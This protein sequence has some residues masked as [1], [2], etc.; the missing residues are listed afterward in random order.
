MEKREI[1][2]EVYNK[3][4]KEIPEIIIQMLPEE[5]V[6]LLKYAKR[7]KEIK[8]SNGID[9]NIKEKMK[10]YL[11]SDE[12]Y[13]KTFFYTMAI[14]FYNKKPVENPKIYV[15]AAQ[16]GSGKSN[17]TAKILN[18][19]ENCVFVDSD[20][21]K[22]FRFDAQ[23][24][25]KKHQILYA[26]L[27]GPDSYDHAENI[28]EYALKNKYN[29]IKEAAPSL[30]K[31]LIEE[32]IDKENLSV[33]ILA[34][35]EL[36]SLLSIHERYE[37]Q[38]IHGLKTAKLT[39]INRH[40]ESYKALEKNVGELEKDLEVIIYKRGNIENNFTPIE[41]YPSG[42]YKSMLEALQKERKKDN[43]KTKKEMEKRYKTI[44]NQ[45]KI[46]NA[47]KEEKAQIQRIYNK[48]KN[49]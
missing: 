36:N 29:I 42:E 49:N 48:S 7:V 27:T 38:I 44:I 28:Y 19:N 10:Q 17:L 18:E 16:T 21:Y 30:T 33:H 9:E 37:L 13:L 23:E 46:R 20:K 25:A 15:V 22:H 4:K 12:E 3:I 8:F 1:K 14:T 26:Y 5:P 35:G 45:M 40:N 24:I 2:I 43:I 41:V 11:L 39:N 47:P 34:V 32:K 6:K 31:K